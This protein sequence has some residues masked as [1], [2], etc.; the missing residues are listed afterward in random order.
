M[1]MV[2]EIKANKDKNGIVINPKRFM[3]FTVHD[4]PAWQGAIVSGSMPYTSKF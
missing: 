1:Q 4:T 2:I 3:Y